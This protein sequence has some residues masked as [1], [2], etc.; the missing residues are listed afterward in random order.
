MRNKKESELYQNFCNEHSEFI[1]E[2]Y[3]KKL[4]A[5]HNSDDMHHLLSYVNNITYEDVPD[6]LKHDLFDLYLKNKF[7]VRELYI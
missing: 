2:Q 3:K 6:S 5:E 1:L 4:F 7:V